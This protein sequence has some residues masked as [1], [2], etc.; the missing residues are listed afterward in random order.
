MSGQ[1]LHPRGKCRHQPCSKLDFLGLHILFLLK[2]LASPR[3]KTPSYLHINISVGPSYRM[4]ND[5]LSKALLLR[6]QS[7]SR[8]LERFILKTE[9][10][11]FAE[12]INRML[13]FPAPAWCRLDRFCPGAPTS[14]AQLQNR[15][16][17]E[18]SGARSRERYHGRTSASHE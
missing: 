2:C 5:R 10:D 16:P 1:S 4:W 18:V 14:V 17:A 15:R 11:K 9:R 13:E 12:V 3:A 6:S 7:D 8:G